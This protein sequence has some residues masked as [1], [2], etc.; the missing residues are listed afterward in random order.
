MRSYSKNHRHDAGKPHYMKIPHERVEAK[1]S[2]VCTLSAAAILR[3]TYRIS[4]QDGV[5]S[6]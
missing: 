1:L 2:P 6:I 4:S 5:Y 3:Y